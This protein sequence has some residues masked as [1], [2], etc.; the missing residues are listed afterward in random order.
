[1]GNLALFAFLFIDP[2]LPVHPEAPQGPEDQGS[3]RHNLRTRGY[4]YGNHRH[5]HKH[6]FG[7]VAMTSHPSQRGIRQPQC[8]PEDAPD[9]LD[10]AKPGEPPAEHHGAH[11]Q[12]EHIHL[13]RGQHY[14]FPL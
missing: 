11:D 5:A 2:I 12:R 10:Q 9:K 8:A 13:R 6:E 3:T 4:P 7:F 14:F 1:M